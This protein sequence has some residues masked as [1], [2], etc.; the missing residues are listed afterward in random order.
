MHGS[1]DMVHDRSNYFSFCTIFRPFTCLTAQIIKLLMIF[2]WCVTNVIVI[3]HFELFF[4]LTAQKI[5]ILKKWNK[6]LEISSFYICV[7]KIKIRWCTVPEICCVTDGR[8]DRRKKWHIEVGA[9]P[10]KWNKQQRQQPLNYNEIIN[11]M[12]VTKTPEQQ[13]GPQGSTNLIFACTAFRARK[14]VL[15]TRS[16][17]Q[18]FVCIKQWR[19]P[20]IHIV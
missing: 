6:H 4:A 11:S 8:T 19:W 13:Y 14:M 3:S 7:L 20:L 16:C 12:L 18:N 2:L 1:W 9:P 10:K 5:K 17:K 15:R